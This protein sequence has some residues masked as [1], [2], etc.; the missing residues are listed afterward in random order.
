MEA[1]YQVRVLDSLLF[2]DGP[3]RELRDTPSFD[4]L[5]ADCRHVE[6]VV[7]AVQ[8]VDA[9]LHLGA[10]VGDPACKLDSKTTL[11]TNLAATAMIKEVCRG[12]GVRR[13]VFASTCS[14]YG[15]SDYL[16]DERSVV[17]PISLY[18]CT[19]V[20]SEH[21]ILCKPSSDFVPT[22]LRLGTAYGWSFRP[23]FDLVVNLL[24]ARALMERKITIF[25]QTQWRPFI[26]LHDISRAFIMCLQAPLSQ[27][28]YEIFNAGS[29]Q[30]NTT[31][32]DM[33]KLIQSLIPGVEVDYVENTSDHRNYRVSF[34]KIH[35]VLGF[36]C[37]KSLEDGILEVKR[38]IE[39]RLVSDYREPIYHN[40]RTLESLNL[41]AV[42]EDP[43]NLLG[44]S[45]KF[46]RNSSA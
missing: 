6:A 2:G 23:R 25:N 13:F 11:E 24:T 17:Q 41:Q 26:H 18:A 42:P 33:A 3:I 45:E 39:S 32:G 7:K 16:L 36:T 10:I 43:T 5:Q 44:E 27:V 31:L 29:Y 19:K 46:L 38:A 34:D 28:A 9:V 12:A 40:D 15:S 14:V 20:D 22:V 1:G 8:G 37:I 35:T 30:M 21:A 4:L